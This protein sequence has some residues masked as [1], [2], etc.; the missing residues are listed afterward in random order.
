MVQI[1]QHKD[2]LRSFDEQQLTVESDANFEC[3]TNDTCTD[4][5][6]RLLQHV[7]CSETKCK[8]PED[9]CINSNQNLVVNSSGECDSDSIEGKTVIKEKERVG[10]SESSTEEQP[11]QFR[12]LWMQDTTS[13]RSPSSD[14][15]HADSDTDITDT[16]IRGKSPQVMLMYLVVVS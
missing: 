1:T 7:E 15:N 5:V 16:E 13:C 3:L 4:E 14:P 2:I 11:A 6:A 8:V 10:L 12:K 9:T